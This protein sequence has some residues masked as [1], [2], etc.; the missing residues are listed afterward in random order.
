MIRGVVILLLVAVLPALASVALRWERL[1]GAEAPVVG[2]TYR[3]A[4]RGG[5]LWLDARPAEDFRKGHVP[6]AV[7]IAEEG[8]DRTLAVV[9]RRWAPG[10]KIVVYCAAGCDLARE[11]AVRLRGDTGLGDVYVLEGGWAA[12]AGEGAR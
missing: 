11:A 2:I 3:E 10:T 6:G 5:V 4:S 9:A 12:A 8:W 1:H 7:S